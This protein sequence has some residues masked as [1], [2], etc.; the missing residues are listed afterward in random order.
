MDKNRRFLLGEEVIQARV[1]NRGRIGSDRPADAVRLFLNGCHELAER[2]NID[3]PSFRESFRPYSQRSETC[4]EGVL[5]SPSISQ[6]MPNGSQSPLF[7]D[8]GDA[9]VAARLLASW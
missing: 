7:S 5:L 4:R 8:D 6:K 3:S 9:V 1:V 2:W